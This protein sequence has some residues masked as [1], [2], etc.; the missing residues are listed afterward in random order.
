MTAHPA[1]DLVQRLDLALIYPPV[2][3]RYLDT[4]EACRKREAVYYGISG[5]R[6]FEEQDR[7]HEQGRMRVG[8]EWVILDPSKIVTKARG[9]ESAHNFGLAA[10]SCR[11][12]DKDRAGLQPGWRL[13]DYLILAEE[14]KK[15]GLEAAYWWQTFREGPHVQLPLGALGTS[16]PKLRA[17]HAGGGI[18]AVWSHLDSLGGW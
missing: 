1:A 17:L 10:D 15:H 14:A 9:G 3:E 8:G 4:L 13:E 12:K 16:L 11:D 18:N 2:V 6:S 5:T 7:L